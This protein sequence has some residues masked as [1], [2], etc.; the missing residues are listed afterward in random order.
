MAGVVGVIWASREAEYFCERDWTGQI[1]L[2]LL[3]KID[4]SRKI[5]FRA[6][7]LFSNEQNRELHGRWLT[8]APV[9]PGR[10]R[11]EETSAVRTD[12]T[13]T[14]SVLHKPSVGPN[15]LHPTVNDV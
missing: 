8:S 5:D 13:P 10:R 9:D 2:K 3:G 11:A 7:Q 12:L 1:T 6:R 14:D 4:L 15:G